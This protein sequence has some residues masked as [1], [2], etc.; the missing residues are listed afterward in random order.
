MQAL[1][2]KQRCQQGVLIFTI[3]VLVMENVG[4]RVRLVTT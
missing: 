2:L 3:A 4:C 1:G